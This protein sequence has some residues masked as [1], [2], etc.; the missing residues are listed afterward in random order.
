MNHIT[1]NHTSQTHGLTNHTT[2]THGLT[3]ECRHCAWTTVESS[4]GKL[5]AAY[6]D[7]L[8]SSH[9]QAWLRS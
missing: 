3:G 8:R 4:Y 2:Q 9:P 1:Q 6:Q 7:H 5:V